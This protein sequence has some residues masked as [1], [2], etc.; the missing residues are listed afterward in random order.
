M[1][2]LRG[3]LEIS[4]G[5]TKITALADILEGRS[6]GVCVCVLRC[7]CVLYVCLKRIISNCHLSHFCR[8]LISSAMCAFKILDFLLVCLLAGADGVLF[9]I[10]YL[11]FSFGLTSFFSHAFN[12]F[13]FFF[14]DVVL[15]L[16]NFD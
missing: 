12:G 16:W 1:F 10:K 2:L 15:P 8:K 4:E 14:S 11:T 3:A 6:A 5:C 9:L 13:D 7:M